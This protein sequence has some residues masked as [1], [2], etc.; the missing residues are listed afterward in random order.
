MT[1]TPRIFQAMAVKSALQFWIKTKLQ[2]NTAYTLTNMLRT[3][4]T[5]TGHKYKRSREQAELAVMDL[6][7]WIEEKQK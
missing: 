1:I 6:Q 4:E 5:I 7:K 3:A 2:V